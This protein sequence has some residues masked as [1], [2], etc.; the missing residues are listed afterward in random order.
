MKTD[1]F[2][3]SALVLSSMAFSSGAFAAKNV[4]HVSLGAN[5]HVL[6]VEK[7]PVN[8]LNRGDDLII[9]TRKADGSL[10]QTAVIKGQSTTDLG[11]SAQ[12][13]SQHFVRINASA[14]SSEARLLLIDDG[15]LKPLLK[16]KAGEASPHVEAESIT[17]MTGDIFGISRTGRSSLHLHELQIFKFDPKNK[18]MIAVGNLDFIKRPVIQK[19]RK[20][21]SVDSDTFAVLD[22]HSYV[23]GPNL[24]FAL[25]Q[26]DMDLTFVS[27]GKNNKIK[28]QTV[29]IQNSQK[30]DKE[31]AIGLSVAPLNEKE[32]VLFG[33]GMIALVRKVNGQ[34]EKSEVLTFDPIQGQALHHSIMEVVASGK[35]RLVVRD[36]YVIGLTNHASHRSQSYTFVKKDGVYVLES[37]ELMDGPRGPNQK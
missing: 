3:K 4:C 23:N 13:S 10:K 29:N 26:M 17:R 33:R 20:S 30:M 9:M 37:Q 15:K 12:N 16:G 5:H 36:R 21:I 2:V 27:V 34:F 19:K 18:E 24:Q 6:Q 22:D 8:E 14:F 1:L 32:V 7:R 28:T 31:N 35:D 11:P 25:Y